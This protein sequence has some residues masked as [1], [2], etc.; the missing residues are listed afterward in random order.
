VAAIQAT[1]R[2]QRLVLGFFAAVWVA[3]VTILLTAPEIYEST[4][5]LGPGAHLLSDL[6][7]LIAI[8]MLIAILVIGVL[9]RWRWAFWLVVVAFVFGILRVP[10]SALQLMDV[11]P[12]G[13]PTWYV[14][15]QGAIGAAQFMIALAMIAGYRKA[16]AWGAF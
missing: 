9:K 11:L 15:L 4:L 1:N 6:A 3:L 16:G 5:R 10:A 7:F 12:T 2:T 13:G 14:L 8:S